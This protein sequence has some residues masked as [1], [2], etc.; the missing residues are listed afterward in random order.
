M[1]AVVETRT[2]FFLK[3]CARQFALVSSLSH[4]E[5]NEGIYFSSLMVGLKGAVDPFQNILYNLKSDLN[6]FYSFRR[7][8]DQK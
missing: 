2:T 6:P 3:I 7:L 5:V 4:S 1:A 8:K